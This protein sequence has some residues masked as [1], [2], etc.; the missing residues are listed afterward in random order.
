MKRLTDNLNSDYIASANRMRPSGA[1]QRIVAY[2]E[3]YE[4]IS[5]WRGILTEW[6]TDKVYFELMLPSRTTLGKGKKIALMNELGKGL[7]QWMIACVD[8]DMD[9]LLQGHTPVSD[10]LCRSPYVIHTYAYAIENLQCWAPSLRSACTMATLN[11]HEIINPQSFMEEYSRII[12]PL[13]VWLVWCYRNDCHGRFSLMD[14]AGVISLRDVNPNNTSLA[15][16]QLRRQVNRRMSLLQRSLPEAK[17]GY[18]KVREELLSM[19]LTPETSYLYVHGHSLWDGVVM[20]LLEPVCVMLR[21]YR[22]RE[23]QRLAEHATQRQN[24][25]SA[26]QHAQSPLE[27][28]LRK[29]VAYK[30]SQQYQWISADLMRLMTEVGGAKK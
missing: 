14:M 2:V 25:L 20:P 16:E 7:G 10:L 4:D 29:S 6:E 30:Q 19:G 8:A 21:R 13:L 24:E 15:L 18:P 17:H 5:F 3:S 1:R 22:E 11:D 26:Y 12:W 27:V 9:W 23:I 28:I